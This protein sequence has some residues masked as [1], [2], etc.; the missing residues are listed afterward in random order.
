MFL[1]LVAIICP[2][3]I[4][5]VTMIIPSR[6]LATINSPTVNPRRPS[7][8]TPDIVAQFEPNCSAACAPLQVKEQPA[9]A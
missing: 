2:N 4:I 3:M 7:L 5:M 6:A 9:V 8:L 1:E